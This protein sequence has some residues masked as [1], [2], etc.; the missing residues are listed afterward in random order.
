[1]DLLRIPRWE[2][3][4]QREKRTGEPWPDEMNCLTCTEW[5]KCLVHLDVINEELEPFPMVDRFGIHCDYYQQQFLT[6]EQY[7]ARTG[8]EWPERCPVYIRDDGEWELEEYWRAIQFENDLARL[9]KDFGVTHTPL[10][11]VCATEAGPPPDDWE[12]EE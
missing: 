11:V 8:K 12:P 5:G 10:L 9:D 7:K 6:P 3:P 2:T 4:E 1:V